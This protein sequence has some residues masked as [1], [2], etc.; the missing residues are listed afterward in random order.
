MLV[1][2]LEALPGVGSDV[3]AGEHGFGLLGELDGNDNIGVV[4]IDVVDTVDQ[5]L[6]EVE[7][8]GLSL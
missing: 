2:C 5:G 6:V 7:D 4:G 8:D 1:G 3:D